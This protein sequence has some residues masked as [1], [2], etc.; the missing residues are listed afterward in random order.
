MK[1][2]FPNL[3]LF[4]ILLALSGC[5]SRYRMIKPS[6]LNYVNK[7]DEKK[8]ELS[9][10]YAVLKE[11]KNRKLAKKERKKGLEVIA[12]KITNQSDSTLIIGKN[13]GIFIGNNQV[14]LLEPDYVQNKIKQHVL[15]YIP[16][17]LF[18][19]TT[20]TVTVQNENRYSSNQYPIGYVLGP[21]LMLGNMAVAGVA[22][23]KFK[24]ELIENNLMN[25]EIKKGETV[26]GLIGINNKGYNPLYLRMI[27]K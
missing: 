25:K 22:N 11:A 15:G 19:F 2:S 17:A 4:I 9:Y 27:E 24:N 23:S 14:Q 5:A 8:I 18:T 16:Y 7:T 21:S 1:K 20:L 3:V 26:Y 6:Q 12:V 10:K 13:A